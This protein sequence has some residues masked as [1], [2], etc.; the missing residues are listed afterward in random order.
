[1]VTYQRRSC[2]IVNPKSK[3]QNP[4]SKKILRRAARDVDFTAESHRIAR[5][6]EECILEK[7]V[8]ADVGDDG[9]ASA[10]RYGM[11][12]S[13]R[14]LVF[15][16]AST[17]VTAAIIYWARLFHYGDFDLQTLN[18]FYYLFVFQDY[19]PAFVALALPVA[20]F[21]PA[22]G[23]LGMRLTAVCGRRPLAVA[24]I[25]VV[26]LC[27]GSIIVYRNYPLSMDEY[28]AVFQSRAFAAG[29]LT[30]QFPTP[31][32][33]WLIPRAFQGQFLTVSHQSGAVASTYWP[34]F[35]LLLA[36]FTLVS[37]PWAVNAILG[38]ITVMLVH[39]LT[40]RLLGSLEAAGFAVLFTL[41]SPVVTI[42]AISYYS[43]PAHLVANMGFALLLLDPTPRR[44]FAAGALGSFALVLHNPVPHML[45]A[46][47][48]VLWLLYRRERRNNVLFL[49]VG[50]IPL[51]VL[52]GLGWQLF[53]HSLNAADAVSA[54]NVS[55]TAGAP[56]LDQWLATLR[57]VFVPPTHELLISRLIGLA[58]VWIWAVPGL[59]L[60]TGGG[61]FK[62]RGNTRLMLVAASAFIT[63]S[64]YLFVPL[65]Q[66]HGWGFRYFHSAWFALPL[67][68]AAAIHRIDVPERKFAAGVAVLS[69][70]FLTAAHAINVRQFIDRH[71]RQLPVNEQIAP[72]VLIVNPA[73]GYYAM[74]LVQNDPLLRNRPIILLSHGTSADRKFMNRN[75]P[76]LR[77]SVDGYKG[78]TWSSDYSSR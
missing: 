67:L 16:F 64:G 57:Q 2:S 30:G 61:A 5:F 4:Q 58:K 34:G 33:D 36:P 12:A 31:L 20:A 51:S 28:A 42:N 15:F 46:I 52:L 35:A 32:I 17:L 11:F 78:T 37:A 13:I 48:W 68:A 1:M 60:L 65:D 70:V 7:Q 77:R 22:I 14:V 63:L 53:L 76:G 26:C 72:D 44:S 27:A 8:P 45:F 75:F 21:I 43:M 3:I 50:Y 10:T 39:K 69:L 40:F 71:L 25:T 47:P 24:A 19:L 23:E 18:I 66:G 55:V 73:F 9:N 41:A 74:D 62:E 38:G 59:L 54:S 29:R 6:L 49:A 56:F